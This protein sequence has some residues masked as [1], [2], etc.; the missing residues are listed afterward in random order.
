MTYRLKV[1]SIMNPPFQTGIKQLYTQESV[2]IMSLASNRRQRFK[3]KI[4]SKC[5]K[6][7]LRSNGK[8]FIFNRGFNQTFLVFNVSSIG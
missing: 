7:H 2:A 8:V 6:N 5:H 3:A 1:G 4:L